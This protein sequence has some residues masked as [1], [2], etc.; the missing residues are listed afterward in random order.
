MTDLTNPTTEQITNATPITIAPQAV[1]SF[2][3]VREELTAI[4]T[5]IWF[6]S[7]KCIYISEAYRTAFIL[8]L[9]LTYM[10]DDLRYAPLLVIDAPNRGCGKSTLQQ[11]LSVMCGQ[12]PE[13]RYTDFTK[14]GLKQ[15]NND[16]VVFLDEID[17]VTKT[18]MRNVTNYLNTSFEASG[19][20][21]IKAGS[22]TSAYGFRCIAGIN[23]LDKLAPATQSRCIRI[24]LQRTPSNLK[25]EKRFEELPLEHLYGEAEALK[26]TIEKYSTKLRYYFAY[27]DYPQKAVLTNR[28]GD[29]WRNMFDLASLLGEEYVKNLMIC[30]KDHGF[31]DNTFDFPGMQYYLNVRQYK[32]PSEPE[33]Y[34][35][36]DADTTAYSTKDLLA[37]IKAVLNIYSEKS[38][39]GVQTK[40]L[41]RLLSILNIK[42]A[43]ITQRSLGR[44]LTNLGIQND[45]NVD[46]S[47]GYRF[48][49]TYETLSTKYPKAIDDEL[50]T[51]YMELLLPHL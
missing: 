42:D 45:K 32:D 47:S 28:E 15:L 30:T 39:I 51:E 27:V 9:F 49:Q 12:F 38:K 18:D 21:A 8:W 41:F 48:D 13:D 14:A 43:P 16:L 2:A 11:F 22:I 26:S 7:V 24:P 6:T 44:H 4:F 33:F 10:K 50:C 37:G 34:D 36:T 35:G 40:E 31:Y 23:A 5:E 29:A 20:Q 1:D 3:D 17:S 25:L 46:K 19:A